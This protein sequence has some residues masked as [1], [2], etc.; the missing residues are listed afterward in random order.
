MEKFLKIQMSKNLTVKLERKPK[1]LRIRPKILAT[2]V[3]P[4]PVSPSTSTGIAPRGA[5]P[6]GVRTAEGG[7]RGVMAG[8]GEAGPLAQEV[9][10]DLPPGLRLLRSPHTQ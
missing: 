6:Q 7:V 1:R 4:V 8:G 5:H 2:V 10:A 3:L 9:E